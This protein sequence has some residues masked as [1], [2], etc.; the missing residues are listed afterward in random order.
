MRVPIVG[1]VAPTSIASGS[2]P[3]A[4]AA[5]ASGVYWS[6]YY[7]GSVVG[8]DNGAS[9]TFTGGGGGVWKLALDAS[10]VYWITGG[11]GGTTGAIWKA[12]RGAMTAMATSLV[13]G[14]NNPVGLAVDANSIYW[15]DGQDA[16][17]KAT[18]AGTQVTTLVTFMPMNCVPTDLAVDADS[19]YMTTQVCPNAVMKA[20]INGGMPVAVAPG[21][22]L[23]LALALDATTVYWVDEGSQADNSAAGSLMKIAK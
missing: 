15:I 3:L 11:T 4:V 20:P 6:W 7:S 22:S 8:L 13:T 12:P 21:G 1:G 5:D 9:V 23:P 19:V 16:V 17:K 18:L 10:S 2:Y 14:L